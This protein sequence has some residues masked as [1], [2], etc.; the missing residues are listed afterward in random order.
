MDSIEDGENESLREELAD[1]IFSTG[2]PFNIVEHPKVLAFLKRLRPAFTPPTRHAIANKYL[3]RAYASMKTK[4][5][6]TL[7]IR[8]ARNSPVCEFTPAVSLE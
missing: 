3:D 7:I 8:W 2:L 5:D 1:V 4:F 6:E